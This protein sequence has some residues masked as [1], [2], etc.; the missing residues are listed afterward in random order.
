V[1][2]FGANK[3]VE[4]NLKGLPLGGY[5]A[6]YG[7]VSNKNF[8]YVVIGRFVYL[9]HQISQRSHAM[10]SDMKVL[11][12]DLQVQIS[13]LEKSSQKE[14]HIACDRLTKQKVVSEL[15]NKFLPLFSRS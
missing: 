15:A 9:H 4:T 10:R 6:I 8:P 12:N 5:E 11:S 2:V 14:L 3:L 13:N 7:P 1:L